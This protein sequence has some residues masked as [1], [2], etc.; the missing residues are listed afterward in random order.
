MPTSHFLAEDEPEQFAQALITFV[1]QYA[2]A[3]D[4]R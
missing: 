2:T 1:D 3:A 4:R